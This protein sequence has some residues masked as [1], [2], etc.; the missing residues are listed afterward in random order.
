[1]LNYVVKCEVIEGSRIGDPVR[2]ARTNLDS[3]RPGNCRCLRVGLDAGYLAS[4][5]PEHIQ[6]RAV[7]A[8]DIEHTSCMRGLRWRQETQ[9]DV[10]APAERRHQPGYESTKPQG[11]F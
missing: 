10:Y 1:M 5:R 8:P 7:A 2:N 4:S 9:R 6:P 3:V 11:G